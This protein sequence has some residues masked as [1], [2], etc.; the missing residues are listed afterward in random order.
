MLGGLLVWIG[1]AAPDRI[2]ALIAAA[3]VVSGVAGRKKRAVAVAVLLLLG[4]HSGI[5]ARRPGGA[6]PIEPGPLTV[7]AVAASDPAGP[8]DRPWLVVDPGSILDGDSWSSWAGPRVLVRGPIPAAVSA[9]EPVLVFGRARPADFRVRSGHVG[10]VIE[11]EGVVRLG[12]AANPLF[13]LGNHLRSQVLGGLRS[14]ATRPEG[15]LLSGFLI[16]DVRRLPESDVEAL[17]L[18]G[19]SHF[20][21][22][23]GSNVA[24]FL[25]AWW[26][27]TAPLG[28]GPRG[29]SAA[30]LLGLGVFVVV[31]RW[32]PSVIRA[33]TMA[34]IVLVGRIA[35]FPVR[36]WTALGVAI[37]GLVA[38]DGSMVGDVGFQLSV[39]AT[40]GILLG[41]PLS[42]GRRPGWL[43]TTLVATAAAQ[44]AVAPL[45]L[46]HF[47][48][49][50]LL[51]PAT[52]L[53][54]APLVA[55]ATT[56]GGV[57]AV[58]HAG[59]LVEA[60]TGL[61]ALVL[62]IARGAAGLPQLGGGAVA[63]LG[64]AALIAARF[65][66]VRPVAAVG[67]VALVLAS[68]VP[69]RSPSGPMVLFL[70]V[71]QGDSALLMGPSGEVVLID[72]GPDPAVLRG[73]LRAR[74]VRRIALL[75]VS[76]RHADHSGGLEGVT[77]VARV[78]RMWHPPQLGEGSP[79]DALAVEVGS[80]GAVVET[81]AVGTRA[82]VGAFSIEVLGPL[83]RYVSPN[84]GS[85][86]LRIEAAGISVLFSGDIEAVAQADLGPLPAEV[87]KVPHQGSLTSNLEWLAASAPRLAV[88]SVGPN[89]FG[90]PSQQVID[91]LE[92]AGAVVRRTDEEG[93]IVVRLDRL[94]ALPSAP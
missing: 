6:S 74:G 27:A 17:R 85:L 52:N 69:A 36:P 60:G 9:G 1:A 89:D 12:S 75:V 77:A 83:R 64:L 5:A 93:T 21:A 76:H 2:V 92:E 68:L 15:A 40:I 53:V 71:G 61:A 34:G 46:H 3:G 45:L 43:W 79:L 26:L 59:P 8:P 51:A 56:I 87:L 54:A 10:G 23:S 48:S 38:L 7:V 49:V 62:A 24:L 78:D 65:R 44:A 58:V 50:P 47:G 33:A 30:G 72:G 14:V 88:I 67:A 81:P 57:G 13:R 22:V 20:V 66:P 16:G 41:A 32:E 25:L 19:L 37:G 84:D 70:D 90:H 82:R 80:A 18:A 28:W 86:V 31:T 42:V 4:L 73:H 94:A 35:G 39:A 63:G 91:V 11:A 29:R 55:G